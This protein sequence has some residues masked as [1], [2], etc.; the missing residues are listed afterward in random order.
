MDNG[1]DIGDWQQNGASFSLSSPSRAFKKIDNLEKFSALETNF[2][3]PL[4][5][6]KCLPI[7]KV[8]SLKTDS[9]LLERKDS[10]NRKVNSSG[11]SCSYEFA[12]IKV[13]H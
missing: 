8:D 12:I 6:R 11:L 4:K 10:G 9:L 13:G 2:R 1:L 5:L 7:M 3:F